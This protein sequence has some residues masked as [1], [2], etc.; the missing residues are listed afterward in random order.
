ME[1]PNTKV[2]AGGLAGA[3]TV[4]FVWL[5]SAFGGVEV[6]IGVEGALVVVVSSIVSYYK[7]EA[8]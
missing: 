3:V 7:K 5:V 4:V 6:P 8:L 2:V 1:K